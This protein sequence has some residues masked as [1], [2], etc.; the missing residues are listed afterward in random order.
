M[1]VGDAGGRKQDT[2]LAG[3]PSPN[4]PPTAGK[5]PTTT[6]ANLS[7]RTV[8]TLETAW[9]LAF[10]LAVGATQVGS[11]EREFFSDESTFTVVAAQL[12]D[13]N[14][15]YVKFFDIKP[16]MIF[17]LLAGAMAAFGESLFVVL[18]LGDLCLLMS[19]IAVFAIAR[20]RTDLA[21]AGLGA[22]LLVA[23]HATE[24][25]F[26]TRTELPAMA[27]LM[28]A[29]WLLLARREHWWAIAAAGLLLSL[30][31][32]TRSNLAIVAAALFAWLLAAAWRPSLGAHRWAAV[33]FAGAGLLPVAGLVLLYWSANGLSALRLANVEA[34]LA[35]SGQNGLLQALLTHGRIFLHEALATPL[36]LLPFLATLA[37]GMAACLRNGR[38]SRPKASAPPA[39]GQAAQTEA[40]THEGAARRAELE[41]L[42]L[43]CAATF[44]SVLATGEVWRHYWLQLYPLGAVF[45]AY[46][47]AW[48]RSKAHLRWVG[49]LLP[50]AAM[51]GALAQTAPSAFR[52][53]AAPG[54]LTE[55]H[56]IKAAAQAIEA[57][58]R[59]GETIYAFSRQLIYWYLDMAP[60]SAIVHPSNLAK[61]RLLR[62]LAEAG[63]VAEDE[64]GRIL[65]LRP[66]YLVTVVQPT[67]R[68][69]IP[70]YLHGEQAEAFSSLLRDHYRVFHDDGAEPKALRVYKL[71]RR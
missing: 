31:V 9:L 30:A 22:L 60:V 69:P 66:T 19:C 58:R 3:V 45:C 70:I 5:P 34:A 8:P 15:P 12:L 50:A 48:L 56:S 55:R 57:E 32:L 6:G 10:A 51:V 11:L 46:G 62:P 65:N 7:K 29:L 40:P 53:A 23:V 61:K 39:P 27:M 54:H 13:G 52:L 42:W 24:Y 71:R 59:P 2:I 41:L 25:A 49:C 28:A 14:L 1:L 47:I 33:L 44:L 35:Y 67:G 17:L 16:P 68:G 26:E 4:Q 43:A 64:L 18:A 21:S 20:R 38:G 36:L 37:I 63:Y